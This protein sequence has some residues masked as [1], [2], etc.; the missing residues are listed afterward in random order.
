M[1]NLL[2]LASPA[3]TPKT[4]NVAV[5]GYGMSAKVF[6]IPL[7]LALPS[8]FKLYAVVQRS[9]KANDDA[10]KDHPG[11]KTYR[12]SEE[13]VKDGKVDVV[14]V[15]TTPETHYDLTI[16]ALSAGKHDR[17]LDSDYL[18]LSHLIKDQKL[19]RI[20][21]FE[22]H[23]DRHRPETPASG[24]W[25]TKPIPGGGAV[26]D[27]GTHLIDQVVHTF[28]LPKRIT[29]F[30]GT[31][32]ENNTNGY[33]DSCTVLLHY[34]GLMATVKAAVVSPE[35]EQLRYWVRGTEGSFKKFY[36]DCQED[37]LKTGMKP[38]DDGFAVEP[39]ERYGTLT[40][41][42]DGKPVAEICPTVEPITYAGYYRHFANALR[43]DADVPVKAEDAQ[44]V[45]RLIELARQSS[46]KGCTMEVSRGTL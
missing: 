28:G 24:G 3:M 22:T 23:F 36:L 6:H 31:Q 45:I 41:I 43:G 5:I 39:K 12:S 15:T 13:M 2:N 9:P 19:G 21:E 44:A 4:Y 46:E 40:S 16:Q 34:D 11:I 17:R 32:R 1:S 37:Q 20:T 35:V 30:I 7:I 18:T 10:A 8:D 33:Q 25:K 14:V 26:Y 29:G 27:L 38:G 42:K